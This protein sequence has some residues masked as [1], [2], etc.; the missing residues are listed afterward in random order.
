MEFWCFLTLDLLEFQADNGAESEK[1]TPADNSKN[2]SSPP[3]VDPQECAAVD[4]A[5]AG[6]EAVSAGK[7][8]AAPAI[9]VIT[10]TAEGKLLPF[11]CIY[12]VVLLV[13]VLN[14]LLDFF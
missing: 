6:G 8:E 3:Q 13:D 1:S 5:V 7:V 4:P 12:A 10:P 9:S 2:L 11:V 14:C